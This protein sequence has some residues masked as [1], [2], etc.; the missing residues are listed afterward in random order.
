MVG[1]LWRRPCAAGIL[2]EDHVVEILWRSHYGGDPV[3]ESPCGGD[4]VEESLWWRSCGGVPVVEI[5]WR[6]PCGGDPV[7]ESLW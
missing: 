4:P 2:I 5:L 1:I 3:E 6:S 7:K